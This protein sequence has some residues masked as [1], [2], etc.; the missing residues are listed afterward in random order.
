MIRSSLPAA[1]LGLLLVPLLFADDKPLPTKP[2]PEKVAPGKEAGGKDAATKKA[3]DTAKKADAA[4]VAHIRLN[5]DLDETP[6][7]GEGLFGPPP[8]NFRSKIDRIKKAAKDATV[9]GLYLDLGTVSVGFGRLNELKAAVGEVK[10][11]GKKVWAYCEDPNTKEY[12]LGLSA[13]VFA[14]PEGG[15]VNLVGLRA[16]VTFYKHALENLKIKADV[17]K[18][19]DYKGAVEPF[20]RDTLSKENREQI[21]SLLDDNYEQEIVA[22]LVAARPARKWTPEQVRGVID[23]G[24]YTAKKAAELGLVD[25]VAYPDAFEEQFAKDLGVEET[26]V[27]RGYEKA[28]GQDLP[29]SPFALLEMLSGPKKKAESRKDKVAVV[30]AV[31]GIE[32]GKGGVNPLMGGNAV[33]SETLVEAIKEADKNPTV[34]AIVLRID[35]PG[36]SALASDMIWHAVV[37]CKKPVVASMGDTA[38]SGGYYIAMGCK[39]IVAEPGTITGSIGVFGLK[40]VTGGLEEWAGMK[41]EVIAR[42]KNSGVN[43]ST[44]AWTDSERKAMTITV[45]DIYDTF[46]DKALEGRTKAG[47][48][49]TRE[50]LLKLA[51]GHVW[52]GRQAK[53]NGLVDQLG[54][55]DVAVAEAKKLAGI[56]PAKELEILVLP[57]AQ[58]IF[59]K[60]ADGD[61]KSPFGAVAIPAEL[62]LLPGADKAIKLAAPLLRTQRD[63]VK[64]M[65]PFGLEWK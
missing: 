14:I 45:Q 43:S 20:T 16:E 56:D 9:K 32:S 33:G 63:A 54:T 39:K 4:Q 51:G 52:T 10:A 46:I 29:T 34:K 3:D 15:G 26:K 61:L 50:G 42:G 58:S 7:A 24:P 37:S 30:Y 62:R 60:L 40:L 6:V 53:A 47:V 25:R 12:L 5:G 41:T 28:K 49:L 65:L 21:E 13:D 23:N 38:A 22:A 27:V 2:M 59:D 55:L 11:A 44:F 35:S 64:V 8:E 19:G 1:A 36:G 57:K 31:G 17:L 18:M 48:K